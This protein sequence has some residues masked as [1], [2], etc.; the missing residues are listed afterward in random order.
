MSLSANKLIQRK[1][2]PVITKL[3][4]VDGALHIYKGA[5]LNYENSNIGYVMPATNTNG[6]EFAGIALEEVNVAAADNTAD[7]T[8]EVEILPRGCGECV[9]LDVDETLTIANEGDAVYAYS[10]DTV[11]L[12][13]VTVNTTGGMV[14]IIRQ[15]V[16]ATKAWVQLTQHPTL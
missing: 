6:Q 14:G 15:F 12:T 11:K 16:S 13:A 10:D 4:C 1:A 3:K 7:G 9:L 2:Q 8:F 5:L